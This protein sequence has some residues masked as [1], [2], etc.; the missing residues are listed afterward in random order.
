[1]NFIVE[2]GINYD[3]SYQRTLSLDTETTGLLPFHG[4][5]VFA[6]T[7]S[8]GI[9]S[10]YL[11]IPEGRSILPPFLEKML[12][13]PNR[14]WYL[15]N[16]KFDMHFLR[17]HFGVVIEGTVIDTMVLARLEF[18]DHLSYSLDA[19]ASRIGLQKSDEVEK[20]ITE[21]KLWEW[22]TIPGKKVRKKNKFFQ[23]VPKEIMVK[24]A[25]LD[26][27][28]T[29][30]LA[31]H[32]LK[33]IREIDSLLPDAPK[34]MDVAK[35][36]FEVTHIVA[37]MEA[38]GTKIDPDY[39]DMAF[40]FYQ[41]ESREADNE[42][43]KLT[44]EKYKSSPKLFAKIFE[45]EKDK[46]AYTEKGNPSFDSDAIKK[47][48]NP[49]A[50]QILTLR[51]AKSRADFFAG[52]NFFADEFDFIH[53]TFN[54]A[55]T[56]TGRFSSSEPNFQN[57]SNDEESEE[58]ALPVR[59]AIIPPDSQY[60]IVSLD[61]DQQEYRMMLDYAGEDT[62]IEQVKAG[63]DVHQATADMMG[64]SR[65]YAKT[66]N[67]MLL[68]GGGVGK[69]ADALNISGYEATKLR[70]LYFSRL[71]KVQKFI[72]TVIHT[73]KLRGYVYNWMGRR[74]F[75]EPNFAYKMPNRIIQGGGAD[76]MKKALVGVYNLLE[77]KHSYIFLTVHDELDIYIH[78]SELALV[79]QI[80]KIMEDA[81]PYK[82]LPLTVS[83][84]HSWDSLGELKDGP[85]NLLP[86]SA[87]TTKKDTLSNV[88]K[89][90]KCY[91]VSQK[92]FLKYDSFRA[93]SGKL[94]GNR[95]HDKSSHLIARIEPDILK[96]NCMQYDLDLSI[97]M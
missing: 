45:S 23:K 95:L 69:L 68:Y 56:A 14:I 31:E 79:P 75:C 97:F 76:V 12:S 34:L 40:E 4:D 86:E 27:E 83:V 59:N 42:F 72:S 29:F 47:F 48:E 84:S 24:Y 80:K 82:K 51:D 19:C 81:Y 61:Y 52:F 18:N 53:P 35:Q 43:E 93:E 37:W 85:P 11:E 26:A 46:W 91:G 78:R 55:G 89:L 60:C 50:K 15:H 2:G 90:L 65:K 67:F 7:W 96:Y 74:Y 16:A 39:S 66:L 36:E 32:L 10:W 58:V 33:R 21:N 41:E 28:V 88:A 22:V 63:V 70:D 54:Q 9:D 20:Y 62:L 94:Y 77:N 71:P 8:N 13:D 44:G 38:G 73:A 1:M 92:E 57:L 64:V 6:I 30:K 87:P 49:A 17:K 5:K 25:C 3:F